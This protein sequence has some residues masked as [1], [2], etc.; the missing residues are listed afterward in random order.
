M[1]LDRE[2]LSLGFT[3]TGDL[4]RLA[5]PDPGLPE[6]S[7][8]LWEHT[9]FEAFLTGVEDEAYQEVNLSPSTAWAAYTFQR[10][11]EGGERAPSIEP[12]TMVLRKDHRLDV[13]ALLR[14]DPAFAA[15]H[16]GTLHLGLTA[17]VETKQGDRSYWALQHPSAQ[18]DFH[19]RAS[20]TLEL[21]PWEE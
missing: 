18:P 15:N 10:Y 16:G 11:R 14:L 9:C 21:L 8:G 4:D 12:R 19:L 5:I 17:V 2:V 20:F 3:L 7:D 6:R 1:F 13:H